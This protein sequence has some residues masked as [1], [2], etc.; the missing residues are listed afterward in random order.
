MRA[1]RA[2]GQPAPLQFGLGPIH[3]IFARIF[4]PSESRS[5]P[6]WSAAEATAIDVDNERSLAVAEAL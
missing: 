2:A 6:C 4:A 5:R 1:L 3:H